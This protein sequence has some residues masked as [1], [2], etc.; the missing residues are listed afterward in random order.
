MGWQDRGYNKS[1][2][3]F[4]S[5]YFNNPIALLS[6]SVPFGT[7]FGIRVRLHFWLLLSFFLTYI[8]A[9]R[10]GDLLTPTIQCALTL[11]ALLC[12]EFGHRI[13]A[14][15]VGGSH[16]EF[17]LWPAG[18]M[19]PPNAP[20]FPGPYFVAHVGGIVANA[21]L[22]GLSIGAMVLLN[23]GL[24]ASNL[25]QPFGFLLGFA[26]IHS[27]SAMAFAVTCLSMFVGVN[28]GIIAVNLLPYY[29]FDGA[30]LLQSILWPFTGHYQSINVTCIVGMVI[31]VPMAFLSLLAG[32]FGL[33]GALFWG[34]L[35]Y[36]SYTKRQQLKATGPQELEDAIAWSAS[37]SG[38]SGGAE[39]T[40]RRKKIKKRWF[41]AARK[42]AR[43]EQQE[44]AKIDTILAKVKEKGLHSLTWGE[45]RT[46]RRATERQRQRDLA[47]RL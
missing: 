24:H 12:H 15:W 34:L 26:P 7:W 38:S 44:Q 17:M 37:Y 11:V 8:A 31:A 3:G 14:Q 20:P 19:I 9:V 28:V 23:A 36:S 39:G 47:N 22:V 30:P 21:I 5:D 27:S 4:T 18:G 10:S 41:N 25:W 16:D 6:M 29:W 1:G 2:G 13:F 46:L 45:K 33:L 32:I 42:R 40:T 43:L 35:F